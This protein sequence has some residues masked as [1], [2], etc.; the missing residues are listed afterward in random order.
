VIGQAAYVVNLT[1]SIRFP[2]PFAG[3]TELL[4]RNLVELEFA[5]NVPD[6]CCQAVVLVTVSKTEVITVAVSNGAACS[7]A[8]QTFPAGIFEGVGP[9]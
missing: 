4:K 7:L 2:Y 1:L 6:D 5:R 3:D 8:V 9:A